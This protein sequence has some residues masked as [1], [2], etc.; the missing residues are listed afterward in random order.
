MALRIRDEE[1]I[2]KIDNLKKKL[3]GEIPVTRLEL[4][5]LVN[6]WGRKSF[7]YTK[8]LDEDVKIDKCEAKE[9]YNLSKLDTSEITDMESLFYFS[10]FHGDISNWNT[11][12]VTTM[13]SIFFNAESFNQDISKWNTQNVLDMA[14][15]FSYA[16][17]FNQDISNWN[18]SNVTNMNSIFDNSKSF[19][20]PFNLNIDNVILM[21]FPFF[22][23]NKFIEKYNRG[24][25]LFTET[26]M[27]K[28]WIKSN[29][30]KMNN[31]YIKDKHGDELDNFFNHLTKSDNQF[32][33]C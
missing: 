31:I 27:I 13:N 20:F 28:N 6:S 12:K 2:G 17:K 30:E 15:M 18:T 11:I 33:D 24:K 1:I 26:D 14:Y 10:N 9:C 21:E 16:N 25:N 23:A 19:D 29:R 8:Y 4:L 22:N 32:I 3:N 5:Y 7:F